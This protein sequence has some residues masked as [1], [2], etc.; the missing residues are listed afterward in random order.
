M[1]CWPAVLLLAVLAENAAVAFADEI[2]Q[3]PGAEQL[4]INFRHYSGY[5]KV[6][7]THFLHYWFVESQRSP[8]QDPLIFWFNGGPGCSS[9]DGLLSEMGPYLINS[10]G[11]TLHDNSF[12]W[13]KVAS[14]VYTES[15]AGVGY[16]YATDGNVTTN[17]QQTAEENYAAVKGFF[18][19]FPSF[20]NNPVYIM[21]ESYGG[22]Y[23]PTLTVQVIRGLIQ[24][25]INLKGIAI[26]NGYVSEVLNIDTSIR[27]AYG[28]GL[29][30]EKTWDTL[31][32][33]CCSGCMDTCDLTKVTPKQCMRMVS[34]NPYDL[35]RDCN[36]HLV[37]NNSRM[38]A[39]KIGLSPRLLIDRFEN[40]LKNKNTPFETLLAFLRRVT[41]PLG[42][43]PCLND[44][45]LTRYMNSA[46]V[47][48]ALHIPHD[49]RQWDICSDE[50]TSKFVKMY[51]DM[52]PFIKE[53]IEANVRVLLYYG[54]TDMACNFMMG[55]QF[56]SSLKVPVSFLLV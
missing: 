9:L 16:S 29:I 26:G 43:V 30:D 7:G 11:K 47:R 17:D 10:D 36:P 28:H 25:P 8:E 39:M 55:Q 52:G 18:E 41:P 46:T 4:Q 31:E 45:A 38:R 32:K 2:I 15:P 44:T 21:G 37:Q 12:A 24:F 23:V 54:D 27:F 33:E 53:I 50:V 13:N 48:Q 19:Q 3:L 6:S 14:L 42:D 22:I 40:H 51:G 5:L 49:L 35:Y 34:L 56:A 20:R 1:M